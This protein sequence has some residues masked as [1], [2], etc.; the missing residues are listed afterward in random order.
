MSVT[1]FRCEQ[2]LLCLD[3]ELSDLPIF[4][5]QEVHLLTHTLHVEDAVARHFDDLLVCRLRG[6]EDS[7]DTSLR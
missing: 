1:D 3:I 4:E 6:V 5:L 7:Q 2:C